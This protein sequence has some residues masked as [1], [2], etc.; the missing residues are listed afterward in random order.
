MPLALVGAGLSTA[1]GA[2]LAIYLA[3]ATG[4]GDLALGASAVGGALGSFCGWCLIGVKRREPSQP[5]LPAD[6]PNSITQF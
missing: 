4:Y 5:S 1:A 6:K 2:L 3:Q